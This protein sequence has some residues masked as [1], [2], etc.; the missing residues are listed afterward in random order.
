MD[1]TPIRGRGDL[2]RFLRQHRPG[3]E[4]AVTAVRGREEFTTR[5]RLAAIVFQ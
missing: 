3:D 4:I 2:T 1:D 5:V